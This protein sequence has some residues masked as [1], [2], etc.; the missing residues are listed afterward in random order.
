MEKLIQE[1]NELK[2][3]VLELE[4]LMGRLRSPTTS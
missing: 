1:N 4:G 3:V 2:A